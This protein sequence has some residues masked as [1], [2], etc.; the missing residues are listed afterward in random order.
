MP[1]L[2]VLGQLA[3]THKEA[4]GVHAEVS[5]PGGWQGTLA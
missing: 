5:S 4:F 3:K 2:H 1:C